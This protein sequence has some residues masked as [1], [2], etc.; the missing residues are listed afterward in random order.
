MILRWYS[1]VS[2]PKD[3][4]ESLKIVYNLVKLE[5]HYQADRVEVKT[6]LKRFY[7]KNSQ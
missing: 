1:F 4:D 5:D 2:D 7:T 6:L 3:V